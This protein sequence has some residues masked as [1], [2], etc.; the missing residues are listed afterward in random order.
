MFWVIFMTQVPEEYARGIPLVEMRLWPG[1]SYA[2]R[3][4]DHHYDKEAYRGKG[5][6]RD[7]E[8]VSKAR[9][10][11]AVGE[12]S[13]YSVISRMWHTYSALVWVLCRCRRTP[14]GGRCTGARP[15]GSTR[16]RTGTSPG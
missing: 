14:R 5:R 11:G 12:G 8:H 4:E 15:R 10:P 13:N 6:V 7:T 1:N 9:A 3:S 2:E 16:F